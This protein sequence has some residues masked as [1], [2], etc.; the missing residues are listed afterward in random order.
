MKLKTQFT[1]LTG[2]VTI[3]PVLFAV[4]F[5]G[6]QQTPHDPRVPTRGFIEALATRWHSGTELSVEAMKAEAEKAG[7]PLR[8]IALIDPQGTVLASTFA[9]LKAGESIKLADL[10]PPARIGDQ[11]PRARA[12]P[13]SE[14]E[15][16][17]E[18]PR[19]EFKLNPL[20]STRKD[21]PLVLFDIQPFWTRQDIKNR[22]VLF[23]SGCVLI[24]FVVAGVISLIILRSISRAIKTIETDTAIVATGDLDH[25][26]AGASSHEILLLA[27]SIN[28]MRLNLKDMLARRSKMLMGVSHD[29]KTPIALIQGYADALADNVATDPETRAKYLNIIRDK[30]R[31]LEDLTGELIDFL[32]IGGDGTMAVEEVDPA[33]MLQT[34]GRRFESDARLLKRN[35]SWGFGPEF[36]ATPDFPV[37]LK[38]MNRSLVERALENLVTNSFKYSRSEGN[39]GLRLILVDGVLAFSITDDGP[40]IKKDDEPYVFDAFYRGSSSRSDGGHGFGLTIVKAVAD[41]HGWSVTIGKRKDGKEGAEARLILR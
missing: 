12:T 38:T 16:S 8:D 41:L 25:E 14:T 30:A 31:Q 17:I 24:L 33:E 29:L 21:S 28:T 34:L 1:I 19:P 36:T 27:K 7:M 26:V 20:D 10:A 39:I 13:D 35:L 23:I 5:F 32:K 4:V 6:F 37:P 2:A 18:G 40:G 11:P 15:V 3:L 9:H 22:N